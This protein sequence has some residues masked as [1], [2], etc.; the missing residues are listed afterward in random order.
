MRVVSLTF[1]HDPAQF[2]ARYMR[3]QGFDPGH[4]LVVT[5]TERFKVYMAQALLNAS[6]ARDAIAPRMVRANELTEALTSGTG[7]PR[8]NKMQKLALLYG[9]CGKTGRFR[10]LFGEEVLSSFS[11][12]QRLASGLL[13]TFEELNR[14]EIDPEIA[15][16]KGFYRSFEEHF[17]IFLEIYNRYRKQ[18]EENGLYDASFLLKKVNKKEIEAFFS[19]FRDV[20]LISPLLLTSFEKRVFDAVEERLH[21]I[22]QDTKDGDFSRLLSFQPEEYY[23]GPKL[24]EENEARV[25]IHDASTRIEAV[26]LLLS[27]VT[28]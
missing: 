14:M 28:L 22:L 6:G 2:A 16:Q 3:D 15:A 18:Q 23:Q 4:T 11:S 5:P 17:G 12:F 21:V 27:V 13:G 9:A 1:R 10:E 19:G 8:A 25:E 20:L 26:T 7:L 24:P